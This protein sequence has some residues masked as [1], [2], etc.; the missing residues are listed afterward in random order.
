MNQVRGDCPRCGG[1][2]YMPQYNHVEGGVCFRCRGTGFS[3]TVIPSFSPASFRS[4]INPLANDFTDNS[5]LST[6]NTSSFSD[7]SSSD[8][9]SEH[10][11]QTHLT[12]QRIA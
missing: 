11:F 4:K 5:I 2:G 3:K 1:T 10:I 6:E 8:V 12:H 7:V 9:S